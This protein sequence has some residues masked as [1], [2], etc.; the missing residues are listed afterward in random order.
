MIKREIPGWGQELLPPYRRVASPFVSPRLKRLGLARETLRMVS[1][2]ASLANTAVRHFLMRPRSV[3]DQL[4]V[5][6]S[7]LRQQIAIALW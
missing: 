6:T 2:A 1:R 4:G 7:A 3:A 5:N